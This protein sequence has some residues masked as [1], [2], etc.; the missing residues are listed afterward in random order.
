MYV[1]YNSSGVQARGG[2][3][4]G[5][6]APASYHQEGFVMASG[7]P[8]PGYASCETV[9]ISNNIYGLRIRSIGGDS[10]VGIFGVGDSLPLQGYRITSL[11]KL[12]Q[13]QGV[14]ATRIISIIRTLPYLPVSFD[15]ALYSEAPIFK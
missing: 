11:G 12:E 13:D 10:D 4:G 1:A 9:D 2:L 3:T 7:A 6:V 8:Q 15:Y 5:A 14:V